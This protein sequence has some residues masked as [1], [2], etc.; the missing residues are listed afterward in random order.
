MF[1][2]LEDI[3]PKETGWSEELKRARSTGVWWTGSRG[4]AVPEEFALATYGNM[5]YADSE[6]GFAFYE[7]NHS[8]NVLE[9]VILRFK[10]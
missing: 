5:F 9:Y 7:W 1:V 8:E 6:A 10:E 2:I 3:T 4:K